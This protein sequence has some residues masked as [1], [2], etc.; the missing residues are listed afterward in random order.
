[1]SL[2]LIQTIGL[3]CRLGL[4][5]AVSDHR[6]PTPQPRQF[7]FQDQLADRPSFSWLVTGSRNTIRESCPLYP[8]DDS[9]WTLDLGSWQFQAYDAGSPARPG[10]DVKRPNEVVRYVWLKLTTKSAMQ[11]V[12]VS[13][14]FH[15]RMM[16][17]MA[18]S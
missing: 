2:M 15:G 17:Y 7:G 18:V 4:M 6:L 9:R 14:I 13:T 8:V 1:M 16:H 5:N 3:L 10:H 11:G 12:Y